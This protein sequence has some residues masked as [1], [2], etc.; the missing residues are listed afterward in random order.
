MSDDRRL[1]DEDEMI[2][3][4]AELRSEALRRAIGQYLVTF[5][6]R[7]DQSLV[8]WVLQPRVSTDGVPVDVNSLGKE[9]GKILLALQSLSRRAALNQ[10]RRETLLRG[11]C[12]KTG[13]VVHVWNELHYWAWSIHCPWLQRP[14]KTTF[15]TSYVNDTADKAYSQ[16]ISIALLQASEQ[17]IEP[18]S[19]AFGPLEAV[20]D[21]FPDASNVPV[22]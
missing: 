1:Q 17:G 2:L 9:S 15:D 14:Y 11:R 10:L 6:E 18:S 16:A 19:V 7:G 8:G 3:R 4:F 5:R 12:D 22:L 21:P 20:P 13:V